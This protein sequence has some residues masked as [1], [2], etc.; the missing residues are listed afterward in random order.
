MTD[1]DYD[2][3]VT[4]DCPR[5]NKR[6]STLL[7]DS[8]TWLSLLEQDLSENYKNYKITAIQDAYLR[9]SMVSIIFET[10]DD[11]VIFKLKHQR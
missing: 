10:I 9:T 6:V 7:Q 5:S 1:D 3:T 11:A 4:L 8:E 2:R